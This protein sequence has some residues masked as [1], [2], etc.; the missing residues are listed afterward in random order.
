MVAG[1]VRERGVA[2]CERAVGR[3][4]RGGSRNGGGGWESARNVVSEASA[5]GGEAARKAV[6]DDA[7]Q[8]GGCWSYICQVRGRNLRLLMLQTVQD[9][10]SDAVSRD[11]PTKTRP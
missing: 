3:C 7:F 8:N 5:A 6:P 1:R 10:P 9:L 4:D 11:R 2:P